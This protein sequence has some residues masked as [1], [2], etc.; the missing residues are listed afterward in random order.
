MDIKD[1]IKC[2]IFDAKHIDGIY[3]INRKC[4]IN[5]AMPYNN[6]LTKYIIDMVESSG[7]Q[8]AIDELDKMAKEWLAVNCSHG[9]NYK[10]IN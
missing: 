2:K 5:I 6:E 7:N 8:E 1:G 9:N 10:T 4:A 3:Y